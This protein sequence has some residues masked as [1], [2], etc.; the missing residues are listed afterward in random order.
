M[1]SQWTKVSLSENSW[2]LPATN[3]LQTYHIAA[4][5]HLVQV[6]FPTNS[7]EHHYPY[8][9]ND[10]TNPHYAARTIP[11]PGYTHHP[12]SITS[13]PP[14]PRPTQTHVQTTLIVLSLAL[15][16]FLAALDITIPS[17]SVPAIARDLTRSSHP[18]FSVG[19]STASGGTLAP[20]FNLDR[21][22]LY[23]LD[24]ASAAGLRGKLSDILGKTR[25]L[26]LVVGVF[27]LGSLGCGVSQALRM[28]IAGLV[29]Q[30]IGGGGVM[31]INVGWVEGGGGNLFPPRMRAGLAPGCPVL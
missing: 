12:P 17:V 5:Y 7:H 25:I 31:L 15:T 9:P 4:P 22:S 14:S 2:S 16:L 1:A 6:Q 24:N 29:V 28:L 13:E 3:P 23:T 30:E 20:G 21:L 11:F 8:H 27:W 19:K 10:H 26:L 18:A